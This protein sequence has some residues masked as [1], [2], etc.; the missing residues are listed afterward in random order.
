[1]LREV[2]KSKEPIL[3]GELHNALFPSP[4]YTSSTD[5]GK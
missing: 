5:H 2:K 4:P 3:K 1:M